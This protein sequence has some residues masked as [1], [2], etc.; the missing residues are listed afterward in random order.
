MDQTPR[1]Q[2]GTQLISYQI[3]TPMTQL[4]DLTW[5]LF[6][7]ISSMYPT[8]S[9]FLK[10]IWPVKSMS[11]SQTW[12]NNGPGAIQTETGRRQASMKPANGSTPN[13]DHRRATG[14]ELTLFAST[15]LATNSRASQWARHSWTRSRRAFQTVRLSQRM[16]KI[17]FHPVSHPQ[18][19][20][21]KL[22]PKSSWQP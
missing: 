4:E 6:G 11:G 5:Q 3:L 1:S 2:V 22:L 18:L 8:R 16:L 15:L 17:S 14:L 12:V 21:Q 13:S 9:T 19:K 7:L 20:L 10:I